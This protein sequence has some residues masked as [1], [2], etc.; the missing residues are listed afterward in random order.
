LKQ[1]HLLN[2]D[3]INKY[4]VITGIFRYL[5]F[6]KC[7]HGDHQ[8]NEDR[9]AHVEILQLKRYEPFSQFGVKRVNSVPKLVIG[10]EAN[11]AGIGIPAIIISVRGGAFRYWTR[12]PY[13]GTGL[14]PASALLF[15]SVPD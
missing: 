6:S 5:S 14:V 7:Q 1:L 11:A 13:S 10:I 3:V 8:Q 4:S 9:T 15:I 2:E 12:S